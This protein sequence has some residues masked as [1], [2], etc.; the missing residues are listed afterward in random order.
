MAIDYV[1]LTSLGSLHMAQYFPAAFTA[2]ALPAIFRAEGLPLE[3]FW[4]FALPAIPRWFKWLIALP[5]D[6]YGKHRFG[7][8]KS[9]IA[10]CTLIGALLYFS[11]SFIEPGHGTVYLIVAILFVKSTIMAAQ[12][13]AVDAMA[14][15]TLT[16][17][18]RTVGTSI[19][20]F[21][22]YLGGVIGGGLMSGV[23]TFG[24]SSIMTVA[25]IM[26]IAAALPALLRPESPPPAARQRR[27]AQGQGASLGKLLRRRESRY[28][29][30][31]MYMFGFSGALFNS[32]ISV[33]LVDRG[34]SLTEIGIILPIATFLGIGG[35]ALLTPVF[36]NRWGLRVAAVIGIVTLPIEGLVF[37]W[38]ATTTDL[39]S[40]AVM[41][42]VLALLNFTTSIYT[43]AVNNS[44]Y[45]WASK[46]QA[47]TEFSMQSSIWNGGVWTAGTVAG[48][49]AALLGWMTFFLVVAVIGTATA[50]VYVVMFKRVEALVDER[51]RLENLAAADDELYSPRI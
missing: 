18:D 45:R 3:M 34:F 28:V 25:S 16:N 2:V 8:R 48:F 22:G 40:V 29:L 42:P 4:L 35:G 7:Y 47:A 32:L 33:F 43:F 20:I 38:F 12:D 24:W 37:A 15:E 51:D 17:A 46:A 36:V 19:I 39:P 11:L 41:I 23:E 13:V 44:R 31:F 50:V 14:T 6:S 27:Q 1:K 5:V 26:L 10:P 49:L 21:M 30:P 9:W